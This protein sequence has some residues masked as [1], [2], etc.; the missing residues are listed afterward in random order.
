MTKC[1]SL[2]LSLSLIL[3]SR[4]MVFDDWLWNLS[5]S[6][7]GSLY[8]LASSCGSPPVIYSPHRDS[9]AGLFQQQH[10]ICQQHPLFPRQLGMGNL[11]KRLSEE[12]ARSDPLTKDSLPSHYKTA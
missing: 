11:A 4:N 1:S 9:R 10:L 7:F 3:D 2:S 6:K 5:A 12:W 8:G